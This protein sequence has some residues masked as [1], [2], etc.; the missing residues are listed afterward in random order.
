MSA[1]SSRLTAGSRLAIDCPS[2]IY[3]GLVSR[4]YRVIS[5]CFLIS[6]ARVPHG[7]DYSRLCPGRHG[8]SFGL[9]SYLLFIGSTFS[10]ISWFQ[11]SPHF[12]LV[13]L[14]LF[15]VGVRP[16]APRGMQPLLGMRFTTRF[17][18]RISQ[19]EVT[20]FGTWKI[21]NVCKNADV[22]ALKMTGRLPLLIFLGSPVP[23][24]VSPPTVF[25][26][27]EPPSSP[28]RDSGHI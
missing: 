1:G 13:W 18:K 16:L 7:K 26:S 25:L 12:C 9:Q 10:R 4:C 20:F 14:C 24:V 28:T 3:S 22:F 17:V 2:L 27:L 6:A 8:S 5:V 11:P 15:A 23:L 19:D 21:L